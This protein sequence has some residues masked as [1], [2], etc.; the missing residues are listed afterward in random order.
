M[1]YPGMKIYLDPRGLSPEIGNPATEGTV[2]NVLGIGGYHTIYKV[3][4]YVESGKFETTIDAVFESAARSLYP[5]TFPTTDEER[6]TQSDCDQSI[7]ESIIE[8]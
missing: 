7:G 1:F 6:E 5:A 2:S 4:S 3:R 8:R